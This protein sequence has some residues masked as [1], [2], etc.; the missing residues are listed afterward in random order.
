MGVDVSE[1]VK[2]ARDAWVAAWLE[3]QRLATMTDLDDPAQLA[4]VIAAHDASCAALEEWKARL[5]DV[6]MLRDPR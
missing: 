3:V 4:V 2:E 6:G 5:R 1:W